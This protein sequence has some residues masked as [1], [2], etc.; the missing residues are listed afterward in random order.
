L[1]PENNQDNKITIVVPFY[2]A[3][4]YISDCMD[5]LINQT[6]KNIEILCINDSSSDN[7]LNI[8]EQYCAKDKRVK[9]IHHDRNKGPGGARNTGIEHSS[10]EYICF[11]DSD[12]YV[13]N[14]FVE[15]L[16]DAITTN[17]SDISA[18]GFWCFSG[19]EKRPC[20]IPY[21]D[22]TY[23]IKPNKEN[24][25]EITESI[26]EA[27]W[28]KMY[29]RDLLINNNI[30][31]PDHRYYEDVLF[32]LKAVY[33]SSKITTIS[34]RLYYYRQPLGSRLNPISHKHIDDRFHF[35]AQIENFISNKI[36]K[37]PN[38]NIFKST[39]DSTHYIMEHLNYGSRLLNDS[40]TDNKHELETYYNNKLEAFLID[41]TIPTLIYAFEYSRLNNSLEKI[42]REDQH[43]LD[44]VNDELSKIA[45][46][47]R[48][49]FSKH[50]LIIMFVFISISINILLLAKL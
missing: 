15:L 46:Q 40:P 44:H 4:I 45:A 43:K 22:S 10:G 2:D 34:K 6:Y 29:N 19:N 33:Y 9:L 36:L 41:C 3:E 24:V 32:W 14:Q 1:K 39:I 21:K 42:I 31:Q 37:Y 13:S 20:H 11:V 28:L 35:I 5:S 7:S 38:T 27:T 50:I 25:V 26:D 17:H 12:D 23:Y 30:F 49:L 48:H 18:C 8:V 16:Y 47:K